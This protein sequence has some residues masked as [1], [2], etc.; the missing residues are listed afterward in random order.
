MTSN[1]HGKVRFAQ[2]CGRNVLRGVIGMAAMIPV[3][4]MAQ[5]APP[6]TA[7][8]A[9]QAPAGS[10]GGMGDVNL[11]PKRV[12][13]TERDRTATVGLY[14]RAPASGD[15]DIRIADMAMTPDGQIADLASLG[16]AALAARVKP[17]SGLLR[18]SP[19]RVTLP[20]NE[21]Q[22]VRIMVRL[23]QGLPPG[24]YRS[25]FS[26]TSVPP[27]SDDVA[28]EGA[29]QVAA[30]GVGVRIVPR[31]GI[32]IPVIV[33]VGQTTLTSGLKDFELLRTNGAPVLRLTILR[34]GTRSSFGD[35]T[36]TAPGVKKPLAKIKGIG[37]YPEIDQRTVQVPLDPQ[38]LPA[39]YARGTRLTITYVDDD[40]EPGKVLA[41]GAYVV[42]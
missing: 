39:S 15:Y 24:E 10:V 37:V 31:F 14:N 30:G 13:L 3:A 27:P 33:R 38:A 35:I 6:S 36:I 40:L 8:A 22:L 19:H 23:P 25:H 5:P 41:A 11:Y 1:L 29:E 28:V 4:A 16:D 2:C 34:S 26:A 9:A 18:W 20:P 32:S 21:A 12:V 17:A 42:P 7:P